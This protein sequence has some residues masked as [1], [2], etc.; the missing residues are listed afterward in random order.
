LPGI[1]DEIHA[2]CAVTHICSPES[3]SELGRLPGAGLRF[4]SFEKGHEEK[5]VKY[6]DAL[7]R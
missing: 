6:L 2:Q 5:Y 4:I 1:E 7:P 3:A